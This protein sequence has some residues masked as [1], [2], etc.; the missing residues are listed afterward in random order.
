MHQM[1]A[2]LFIGRDFEAKTLKNQPTTFRRTIKP[3]P[4]A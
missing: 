1:V 2:V 4:R 3:Q